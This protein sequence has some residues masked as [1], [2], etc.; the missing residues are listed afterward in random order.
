MVAHSSV[1]QLDNQDIQLLV[2]K[3]VTGNE[4]AFRELYNHFFPILYQYSY[5]LLGNKEDTRDVVQEVFLQVHKSVG[6]LREREKVS[7][8][9][10]TITYT[11]CID[12]IRR[13]EKS[14]R[15]MK[16]LYYEEKNKPL[17]L[18]EVAD[19]VEKREWHRN[20]KK[21]VEQLSTA[22]KNSI[23]LFYQQGL[24]TKEI[25]E[26]QGISE[27]SVRNALTGAR[28]QIR[29][30]LENQGKLE[31]K[32]ALSVV[33]LDA[34]E[35]SDA[36]AKIWE[37]MVS[38]LSF[39]E[40]GSSTSLLKSLSK[41]VN[42]RFG[43]SFFLSNYFSLSQAVKVAAISCFAFTALIGEVYTL[44]QKLEL[45]AEMYTSDQDESK[46]ISQSDSD[47]DSFLAKELE[48]MVGVTDAN[49]IIALADST[50]TDNRDELSELAERQDMSKTLSVA[51]SETY[52]LYLLQQD[53]KTLTIYQEFHEEEQS[54][55][56]LYM[57]GW[58]TR[59]RQNND[60]YSE[61]NLPTEV[62]AVLDELY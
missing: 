35:M 21:E 56:T 57:I 58:K 59:D 44:T 18:G 36:S 31:P 33:L 10:Y 62:V 61:K 22:K 1:K 6:T 17:F 24:S 50:E 23:I 2:S 34:N 15:I 60:L 52:D 13:R 32:L 26:V 27:G 3:I 46:T 41:G 9:L 54:I 37:R 28:K 8:W 5:S 7:N 49:I 38:R 48:E 16:T 25:A 20:I 14:N 39:S 42:G 11:K 45:A 19:E 51:G 29:L 55:E 12:V 40:S 43:T 30:S 53:G 4:R 47:I